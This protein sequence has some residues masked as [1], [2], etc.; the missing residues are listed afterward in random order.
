MLPDCFDACASEQVQ[1]F[2][3]WLVEEQD[4]EMERRLVESAVVVQL[5]DRLSQVV[6][7]I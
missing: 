5:T 2:G 7:A 1:A 4:S 3:V 6:P